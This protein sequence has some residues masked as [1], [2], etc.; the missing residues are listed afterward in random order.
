MDKVKKH[1]EEEAREFDEIILKLIPYY[2]EMID[3]LITAI[4]FEV[5]EKIKVIDLGCGTGTIAKKVKETY[6]NAQITCVDLAENMIEMAKMKL[7]PYSDIR[8]HI[9]DFNHFTFTDSYD[10][11]ISS[12]ALHH[13]ES[14]KDKQDFYSK[15]YHAL[16]PGGVFYNADVVLASTPHLQDVYMKQWIEF[17]GKNVSKQEIEEKWLP[18]YRAEDHP[19]RLLDQLAWFGKIGYVDTDVIWKFYSFAVYGGAK[20]TM[21]GRVDTASSY[22]RG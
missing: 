16:S 10:V 17:M 3:A 13:L 19:A 1:F 12:L 22:P 20:S 6:P 4:P 8:Y 18:T 2:H 5:S 15:I 11:A 14:D 21:T 9:S 7:S